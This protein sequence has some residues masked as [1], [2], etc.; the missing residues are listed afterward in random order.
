MEEKKVEIET[1][2]RLNNPLENERFVSWFAE[3]HA[4]SANF[5]APHPLFHTS[6]RAGSSCLGQLLILLFS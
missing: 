6:Q 5:I 2:L 4:T 3:P 1:N